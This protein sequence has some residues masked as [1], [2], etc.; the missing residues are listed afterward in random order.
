MADSHDPSDGRDVDAELRALYQALPLGVGFVDP[1]LR[2]LRVNDALARYN[3]LAPEEHIG[4]SVTEV[5]GDRGPAVAEAMRS[6]ITTRDPVVLEMTVELPGEEQPVTIEAYYFPVHTAEGRLL[7]VGGVARDVSRQREL[8]QART[9]LLREAVTAR[10]DAESAQEQADQARREAEA[11]RA[12]AEVAEARIALLA[13]AG[14]RMAESIDWESTLQA[15][16]HSAVP[17]VADWVALTIVE[18]S[19][20]LRVVAVGHADPERERLAWEFVERYTPESFR[21]AAEVIRTGRPRVVE[22]VAPETIRGVARGQEHLRLLENLNIRHYAVAPLTTHAG[23]IGALTFVLGDSDRRFAHEDLE[24]IT[25]LAARAGLHIQNARLYAERSHVAD[26]LQAS[27]RP[28]A[29][30]AIPGTEVAARFRPAGDQ[31]EVGGDFY[32]VFPTSEE[33]WAAIIGDVSG[34]GPEAAAVTALARHT[35]R[36]VSLLQSAPAV[37]LTLLNRAMNLDSVE[38]SLCTALFVRLCR[39]AAGLDVRFANAGH[40]PPLLLRADGTIEALS[41]G[42]GPL[43]GAFADASYPEEVAALGRGDLLLMYTDGVTEIRRDDPR[44]GER[45]LRAVVGA[46]AGAS[47][48]Q[49]VAAV[50]D[51]A[52]ELADGQPPDDIALLAVRVTA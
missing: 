43:V 7:G 41:G 19:G 26:V 9:A 25:T 21:G 36:A 38:P 8:E 37:N 42:L 2:Y 45:E 11:A 40:P 3:G 39:T 46:C 44:L 27:L 20:A 1:Q 51:R 23:V 47:A 16:V 31:I 10:A 32:D 4:R 34:K 14:R 49:V 52:V 48:E 6:V 22:D 12:A 24:L 50:H 35:L 17:A 5:V 29:L 30:P 13:E 15:V 28:R 18:P 33:T